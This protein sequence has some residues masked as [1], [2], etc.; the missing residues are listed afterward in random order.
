MCDPRTG[1]GYVTTPTYMHGTYYNLGGKPCDYFKTLVSKGDHMKNRI[2]GMHY[3][4][5]NAKFMD[6]VDLYEFVDNCVFDH[7]IKK[8]V[9]RGMA[10]A[11]A[12]AAEIS[13]TTPLDSH[14]ASI[15]TILHK[16]GLDESVIKSDAISTLLH[17]LYDE[18]GY[19]YDNL[20]YFPENIEKT[21]RERHPDLTDLLLSYKVPEP[22]VSRSSFHIHH[23]I[24]RFISKNKTNKLFT[25]VKII[26]Q[27]YVKNKKYKKLMKVNPKFR[28]FYLKGLSLIESKKRLAG[29]EYSKIIRKSG[30][31]PKLL[32][33]MNKN[34]IDII[35][36]KI[37]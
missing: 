32:K 4:H 10:A 2:V 17:T 13:R 31:D 34:K 28:R 27:I 9:L 1:T 24:R 8:E 33:L 7:E 26:K 29:R 3:F 35:E 23:F 20:Y 6:M 11:M 5:H 37:K 36:H 18:R 15:L 25:T 19:R 14:T 30:P 16:N 12:A 22:S 21:F